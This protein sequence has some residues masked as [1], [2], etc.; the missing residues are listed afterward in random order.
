MIQQ[1]E[2]SKTHYFHLCLLLSTQLGELFTL[3]VGISN[4]EINMIFKNCMSNKDVLE[5]RKELE[6]LNLAGMVFVKDE[7]GEIKVV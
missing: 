7:R 3:S 5:F 1:S 6:K 4:C 2:T